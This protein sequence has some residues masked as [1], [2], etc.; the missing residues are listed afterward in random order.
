MKIENILAKR[1][2]LKDYLQQQ[3]AGEEE[4]HQQIIDSKWDDVNND[5]FRNTDGKEFGIDTRELEEF[6]LLQKHQDSLKEKDVNNKEK[7]ELYKKLASIDKS[8]NELGTSELDKFESSF[9]IQLTSL[10]AN[11]NMN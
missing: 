7:Q 1:K 6:N 8:M 11:I 10:L 3:A 5:I 2:L 4:D 9:K